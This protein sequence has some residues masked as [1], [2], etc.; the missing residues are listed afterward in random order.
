MP[1][2]RVGPPTK[3]FADLKLPEL[4]MQSSAKRKRVEPLSAL[5]RKRNS[6]ISLE[7]EHLHAARCC[8]PTCAGPHCARL[9]QVVHYLQSEVSAHEILV[10]GSASEP[11]S[12]PHVQ[13][14]RLAGVP[15][16]D[17]LEKQTHRLQQSN[18]ALRQLLDFKNATARTP[19]SARDRGRFDL[20]G[21]REPGPFSGQTSPAARV[22]LKT[23]Q[24]PPSPLS[25]HSAFSTRSPH[26]P[27]PPPPPH[28]A[29]LHDLQRQLAAKTAAHAALQ[30][31][32]EAVCGR[33]ER[34]RARAAQLERRV[35]AADAEVTGLAGDKERLD[36][37][38]EALEREGERLRGARDDA[39]KSAADS[40]AQYLRIVENA[41][42]IKEAGGSPAEGEERRV[43]ERERERL[44]RRVEEL[45]RAVEAED[46]PVKP[47]ADEAAKDDPVEKLEEDLRMLRL[48]NAKLEEVFLAGKEA[49]LAVAAQSQSMSDMLTAAL[50]RA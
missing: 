24:T 33:L 44:V 1:G 40:A 2:S 32:H 19:M 41:G 8:S 31:E 30:R 18:L 46:R 14:S 34:A 45:E 49:A 43:W 27:L 7:R 16:L 15:L 47:D 26:S 39:R 4:D 50:D 48:R 42:R 23:T 3:W 25:M 20:A 11:Q 10:H 37:A 6:P 38:V 12:P 17:L 21:Q 29:H 35:E 5:D 28:V 22:V 9:R 36:H 13:Q